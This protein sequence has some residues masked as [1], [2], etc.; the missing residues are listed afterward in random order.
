MKKQNLKKY[1]Y[2]LSKAEVKWIEDVWYGDWVI[3]EKVN[4]VKEQRSQ[5]EHEEASVKKRLVELD[6][7]Q[8]Y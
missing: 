1:K 2:L 6:R 8:T 3:R 4:H 5:G 7:T